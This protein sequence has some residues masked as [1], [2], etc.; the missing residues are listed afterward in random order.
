MG[1]VDVCPYEAQQQLMVGIHAPSHLP[2]LHQTPGPLSADPFTSQRRMAEKAPS[3]LPSSLQKWSDL[4]FHQRKYRPSERPSRH[5]CASAT[6]Q[7][8]EQWK[9][10]IVILRVIPDPTDRHHRAWFMCCGWLFRY[11]QTA[12]LKHV[13]AMGVDGDGGTQRQKASVCRGIPFPRLTEH[14]RLL[15]VIF[16]GYSYKPGQTSGVCVC[17]CVLCVCVGGGGG[18]N[19]ERIRMGT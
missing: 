2:S 3:V 14:D 18:G 10:R 5:T 1:C 13:G 17:V 11:W 19:F 9:E 15:Q 7:E 6:E 8:R 16:N 4:S 12:V